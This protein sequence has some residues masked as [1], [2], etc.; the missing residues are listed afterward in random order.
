MPVLTKGTKMKETFVGT[1]LP[2][3]PQITETEQTD[4]QGCRSLQ[5]G[6]RGEWYLFRKKSTAH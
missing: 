6:T 4:R 5:G 3:G 1:G 2:D